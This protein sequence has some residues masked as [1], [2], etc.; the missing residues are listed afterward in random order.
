ME[1]GEGCDV[2][3]LEFQVWGGTA[4]KS[5][6]C[7]SGCQQKGESAESQPVWSDC[8]LVVFNEHS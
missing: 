4:A 6:S 2:T 3:E 5:W 1:S 8:A 7:S